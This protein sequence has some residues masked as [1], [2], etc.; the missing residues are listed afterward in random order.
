MAPFMTET[1][2]IPTNGLHLH[3]AAAGPQDGPLVIL[4]HGFP[5]FWYGWQGQIGPLAR[6][7]LR[8]VAPDMRGYNLSDKPKG[9]ENYTLDKLSADVAGI[10]DHFGRQKAV[11]VGHDWGGIVAWY[12]AMHQPER[13][14]GL[15]VMNAPHPGVSREVIRRPLLRQFPKS[16][17]ILFFQ[18]AGLAEWSLRFNRFAALRRSMLSSSRPG[19]F[20]DEDMRRYIEA[21]RQSGAL[22]GGLNYYRALARKSAAR[23]ENRHQ[24]TRQKISVPTLILWGNQDP[25]LDP[26]LADWSLSWAGSARLVRFPEATHWVQHEEAARVNHRILEFL[27]GIELR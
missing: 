21:W 20:T 23:K 19:T 14:H 26:V 4:L 18:F 10:I 13:L 8:V 22:T 6:S 7:G 27:E 24:M 16:A 25:F 3:A 1:M 5:E 9:V 15:T 12:L 2:I 17:Y 11:V